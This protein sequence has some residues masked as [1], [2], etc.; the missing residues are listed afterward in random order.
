MVVVDVVVVAGL[1]ALLRLP[2]LMVGM[3]SSLLVNALFAVPAA[4][5]GILCVS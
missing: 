1:V 2:L 4:R 3:W 5:S